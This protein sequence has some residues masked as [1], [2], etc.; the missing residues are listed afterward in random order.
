[1]IEILAHRDAIVLSEDTVSKQRKDIANR[2]QQ[3]S[4]STGIN[5]RNTINPEVRNAIYALWYIYRKEI[6]SHS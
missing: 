3:T 6:F 5:T 2:E 4:N 1:M